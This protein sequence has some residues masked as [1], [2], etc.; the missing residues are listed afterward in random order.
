MNVARDIGIRIP[1]DLSITGFDNLPICSLFTPR[2]TTVA[3]D[4]SGMG[5]S[6]VS[7]LDMAIKNPQ[8]KPEC[9]QLA[10]TLILGDTVK[11][12]S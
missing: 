12:I 8:R 11:T 2:L 9:I 6:A 5:E 10:T 1:E 7:L 4:F 3:Q